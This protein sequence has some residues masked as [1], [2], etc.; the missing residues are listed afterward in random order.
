[1]FLLRVRVIIVEALHGTGQGQQGT[2]GQGALEACKQH[3]FLAW[4]SHL[5]NGKE[6]RHAQSFTCNTA[7]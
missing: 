1:M 7:S 5:F 3:L 2:A 6:A 4:Y